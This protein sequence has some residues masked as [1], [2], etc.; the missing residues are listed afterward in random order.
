MPAVP[1]SLQIHF[2]EHVELNAHA[3]KQKYTGGLAAK[4]IHIN[5]V[6]KSAPPPCIFMFFINLVPI[7]NGVFV[8]EGLV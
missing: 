2:T 3:V 6:Q 7:I 1:L 4:C 8:F 5:M